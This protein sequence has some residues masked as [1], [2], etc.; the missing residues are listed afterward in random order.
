MPWRKRRCQY[1]QEIYWSDRLLREHLQQNVGEWRRPAD[2]IHDFSEIT[3]ILRQPRQISYE[4]ADYLIYK[5]WTCAKVIKSRRRFIE[6]VAHQRHCGFT[7]KFKG[8]TYRPRR[9]W[10]FKFSEESVL[11]RKKTFPFFRLPVELR[12]MVYEHLLHFK[13]IVIGHYRHRENYPGF[14]ELDAPLQHNPCKNALA[15]MAVNRQIY[16]EARPIF[17]CLNTFTFSYFDALPI[18]L[19]GVGEKNVK[20]LQRVRC[21]KVDTGKEYVHITKS[22]LKEI[23]MM[24]RTPPR[25][26]LALQ[27]VAYLSMSRGCYDEE[28]VTWCATGNYRLVPANFLKLRDFPPRRRFSLEVSLRQNVIGRRT[29]PRQI[30]ATYELCLQ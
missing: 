26:E 13:E 1:C 8:A 5:C 14:W 27:S 6:H 11:I 21:R 24:G 22:C 23:F 9:P 12:M 4:A 16:D 7:Y 3:Q 2:G 18:F 20:L 29:P 10:P 19:I 25:A 17:Y 30:T 15:I 28:P